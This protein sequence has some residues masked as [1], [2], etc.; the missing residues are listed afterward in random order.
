MV[1]LSDRLRK[2]EARLITPL[3]ALVIHLINNDRPTPE[4]Q[5]K[6]DAAKKEGRPIKTVIFEVVE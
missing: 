4:Q 3:S 1:K 6:I 2:L 5:I